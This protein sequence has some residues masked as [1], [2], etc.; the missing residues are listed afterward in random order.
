M[1]GWYTPKH[2]SIA[3][4]ASFLYRTFNANLNAN[5]TVVREKSAS[6]YFSREPSQ[7]SACFLGKY[8]SLK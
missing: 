1:D 2:T 7:G 8:N 4:F 6:G 3:Y 5:S